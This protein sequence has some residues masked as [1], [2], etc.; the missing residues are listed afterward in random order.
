MR[1]DLGFQLIV[2]DSQVEHQAAGR[3]VY[4]VFSNFNKKVNIG[5]F[6]GLVPGKVFLNVDDFKK[7]YLKKMK[8]YQKVPQHLHF[9][10]GKILVLGN[11]SKERV[12][13][14]GLAEATA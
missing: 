11:L 2:R 3:G 14:Y 7:S 1:Y 13:P 4:L 6:L 10:S 12:K 9:P 8:N 5:D